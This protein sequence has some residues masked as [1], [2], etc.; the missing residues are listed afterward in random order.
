MIRFTLQRVLESIP[1]LVLLS[2]LIFALFKLIPGD[3]LTEME[4]DPTISSESVEQLRHEFGLDRPLVAQYG[5]WMGQVL[6]GNFGYSFA[7]R[8]PASGLILERL[9]ATLMLTCLAFCLTVVLALPLAVVSALHLGTWPDRISLSLSLLG[10]SLPTVLCSLLLLYFAYATG[11]F[12]IGGA[13][14]LRHATLPAVTL[15]M[16]TFAF[17]MRTLRLELVDVLNQP[18]VVAAAAKGLPPRRVL[19]HAFRN[20][21]NPVISLWSHLGWTAQRGCCCRESV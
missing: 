18:Y 3:Y 16:P 12:P 13:D 14:S 10:L 5:L 15:A 4:L 11:W 17:L 21:L 2:F 8:R 9:I 20:A 6:R 19:W 1:L 7:Q